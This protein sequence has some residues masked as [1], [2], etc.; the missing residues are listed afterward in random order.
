MNLYQ[1]QICR[2]RLA[3]P[4]IGILAVSGLSA[5][6]TVPTDTIALAGDAEKGTVIRHQATTPLPHVGLYAFTKAHAMNPNP[7]DRWGGAVTI[8]ANQTRGAT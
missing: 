3:I 1:Q 2:G 6:S 5:C 8:T 7:P 4:L